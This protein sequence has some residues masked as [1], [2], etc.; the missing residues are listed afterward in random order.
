MKPVQRPALLS[1]TLPFSATSLS[2][3]ETTSYRMSEVFIL[4]PPPPPPGCGAY[5]V[6]LLCAPALYVRVGAVRSQWVG[7]YS[8]KWL[9]SSK[10]AGCDLES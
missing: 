4:R 9:I 1:Q 3:L 5:N 10:I 8:N 6:I 2:A 7:V